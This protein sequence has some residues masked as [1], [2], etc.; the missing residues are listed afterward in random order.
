MRLKLKDKMGRFN[1][2]KKRG[3]PGVNT[4]ALPDI[5]FMLLFFFMVATTMKEQDYLV[6]IDKPTA[7]Q[8]LPIEDKDK[9]DFVYIGFPIDA[10]Q[11]TEPRIQLNDQLAPGPASVIPWKL[12]AVRPG[13][14]AFDIPTSLKVHKDVGMRVVSDVKEN[15]REIDAIK[16]NY[17]ADARD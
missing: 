2:G 8:A 13:M 6:E 3:V 5:I 12:G 14:R 15:L 11:G 4:S 9:I 10:N 7:S 17:S 1:K 16:I